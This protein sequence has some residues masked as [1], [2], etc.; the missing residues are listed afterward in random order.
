MKRVVLPFRGD[1][2]GDAMIVTPPPVIFQ[3]KNMTSVEN[4]A[5]DLA[6]KLLSAIS[7]P[8]DA[9]T[10]ETAEIFGSP[11]SIPSLAT[12]TSATTD[13]NI[14]SPAGGF[15]YRVSA[16]GPNAYTGMHA[17]K[18]FDIDIVLS[19][20]VTIIAEDGTETLLTQGDTVVIERAPHAWR[21]GPEGALVAFLMIGAE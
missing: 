15:K 20:E 17:T 3:F 16:Y 6:P 12:D 1:T 9:N 10:A 11:T 19:G 5:Y 4:V 14:D 21:S 18:T 7:N 2:A 13:W 8:V